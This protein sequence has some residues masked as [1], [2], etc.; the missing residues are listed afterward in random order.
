MKHL[1]SVRQIFRANTSL[2]EMI[3]FKLYVFKMFKGR[4]PWGI[5]PMV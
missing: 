2:Y 3:F 5:K 4:Q 1:G